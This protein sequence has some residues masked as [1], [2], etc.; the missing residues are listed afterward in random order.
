MQ[1]FLDIWIHWVLK[2]KKFGLWVQLVRGIACYLNPFGFWVS[3]ASSKNL[4]NEDA[5]CTS[6]FPNMFGSLNLDSWSWCSKGHLW[7][8]LFSFPLC[9]DI[10]IVWWQ[11]AI[12]EIIVP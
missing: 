8:D 10:F 2:D 9:F 6:D 11:D 3:V 7:F 5:H 1:A 12:V 4:I